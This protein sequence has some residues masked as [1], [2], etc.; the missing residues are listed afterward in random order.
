MKNIYYVYTIQNEKGEMRAFTEKVSENQN[1]L[2]LED[3]FMR[4]AKNLC[5]G[6]VIH[7][8]IFTKNICEELEKKW[9]EDYKRNGNFMRI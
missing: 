4:I 6:K 8:N 5:N 2:G 7:L 1:L 3:Y 9:N